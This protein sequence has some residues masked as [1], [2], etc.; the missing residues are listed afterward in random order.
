MGCHTDETGMTILIMAVVVL[1]V[2]RPLISR[3][4]AATAG[5]P[6]EAMVSLDDDP[7]VEQVEIQEGESLEDIKAKLKPKK[8]QFHQKCWIP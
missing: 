5:A 1:G 6:G 3:I 8:Q 4:G 2:I 7:D